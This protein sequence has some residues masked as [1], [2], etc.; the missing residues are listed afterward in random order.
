MRSDGNASGYQQFPIRT[1]RVEN[2]GG[3]YK[4][5]AAEGSGRP[6]NKRTKDFV[7]TEEDEFGDWPLSSGDENEVARVEE[8]QT[9]LPG[10]DPET[11]QRLSRQIIS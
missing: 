1:C 11:P 7:K 5:K 10:P 9:V 6:D 4:K 3:C 2:T 8:L